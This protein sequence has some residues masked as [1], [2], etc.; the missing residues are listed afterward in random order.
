[1]AFAF[2]ADGLIHPSCAVHIGHWAQIRH[3]ITLEVWQLRWLSS[4]LSLLRLTFVCPGVQGDGAEGT[5]SR[6]ITCRLTENFIMSCVCEYISLY[7]GWGRRVYSRRKE[8]SSSS[9]KVGD[10]L[11]PSNTLFARCRCCIFVLSPRASRKLATSFFYLWSHE[12]VSPSCT[13]FL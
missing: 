8:R 13:Y 12:K 9:V 10:W 11:L 4:G 6:N 3:K 7:L 2:P 1:M 5:S